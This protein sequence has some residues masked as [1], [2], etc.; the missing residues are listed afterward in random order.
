MNSFYSVQQKIFHWITDPV[1]DSKTWTWR[2]LH[3]Y[4]H[5]Q[6]YSTLLNDI[7][8]KTPFRRSQWVKQNTLLLANV[9]YHNLAFGSG[10]K[11]H[12]RQNNT[13][14]VCDSVSDKNEF[15]FFV[16]ELYP[17][18]RNVMNV[19][20]FGFYNLVQTFTSF[21]LHKRVF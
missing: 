18:H 2:R 6:Q 15:F 10:Y 4:L 17:L 1:V 14:V 8:V 13:Q 12:T 19:F 20:I 3:F 9:T 11:P 21:P 7:N 5:H 16:T